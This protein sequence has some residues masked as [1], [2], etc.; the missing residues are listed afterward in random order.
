MSVKVEH[1]PIHNG[2]AWAVCFSGQKVQFHSEKDAYEYA[3][4]LKQRI[5]AAHHYPTQQPPE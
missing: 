5:D 2:R 1:S 4:T 3:A